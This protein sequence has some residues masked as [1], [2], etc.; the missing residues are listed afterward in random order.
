MARQEWQRSKAVAS[1]RTGVVTSKLL[2]VR[3]R[4]AELIS[5]PQ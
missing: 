3:P 1:V 2:Q 5:T 4:M